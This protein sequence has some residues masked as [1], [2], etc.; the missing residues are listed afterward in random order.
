MNSVFLAILAAF[1]FG[2]WTV[3][4]KIA[5]PNINRIFGALI[6]QIAAF[7]VVAILLTWLKFTNQ[8]IQITQKGII[9]VALAGVAAAFIDILALAAYSKGLSVSVG[10]PL[11]IGGSVAV[12]SALGFLMGDS[13]TPIKIFAIALVIIGSSILAR[14]S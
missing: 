10:G 8:P 1:S 11:I 7:I 9:F 14:F 5:A 6:V 12:A 4:H 13:I 2:L 3:F